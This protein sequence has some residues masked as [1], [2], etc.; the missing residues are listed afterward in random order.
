MCNSVTEIYTTQEDYSRGLQ[1]SSHLCTN[2]YISFLT[3]FLILELL[4]TYLATYV[5]LLI[6]PILEG[7][8]ISNCRPFILFWSFFEHIFE[9]IN[10]PLSG[11]IF[12]TDKCRSED[13]QGVLLVSPEVQGFNGKY[14][15]LLSLQL[16]SFICTFSCFSLTAGYT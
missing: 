16:S 7:Q 4:R 3:I 1:T 2:P 5:M 15:A 14:N 13:Q 10:R 11:L 12:I 6:G 8:N 9:H